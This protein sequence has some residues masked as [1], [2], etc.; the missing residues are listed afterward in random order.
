MSSLRTETGLLNCPFET[1]NTDR[2]GGNLRHRKNCYFRIHIPF[3]AS[4]TLPGIV[5]SCLM[6]RDCISSIREPRG[7]CDPCCQDL[8]NPAAHVG[9][10]LTNPFE[11]AEGQLP[12]SQDL[13]KI[14]ERKMVAIEGRYAYLNQL[15]AQVVR[16]S[17]LCLANIARIALK[18]S[19]KGSSQFGLC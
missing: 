11:M 2:R 7:F 16:L 12:I 17:Y 14:M 4:R 8:V 15:L 3:D 10:P 6:R 5:N 13:L 18:G 19:C 1:N 9:W